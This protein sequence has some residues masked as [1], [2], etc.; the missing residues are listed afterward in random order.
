MFNLT[1]SK[2]QP[3]KKGP[4]QE[5]NLQ[6]INDRVNII[7]TQLGNSVSDTKMKLDAI[8]KELKF[9]LENYKNSKGNAKNSAKAKSIL[10]SIMD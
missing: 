2:K 6:Q 3:E 1:G 7:L 9:A 5:I 10:K 4:V 8:N